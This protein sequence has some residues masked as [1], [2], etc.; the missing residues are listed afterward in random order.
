MGMEAIISGSTMATIGHVVGVDADEFALLLHVGDDV[1][2]GNLGGGAGGGGNGDDGHA[3]VLGGSDALQAAHV[4]KFGVGDD[5]ADGLGGVHGG[6]AADGDDVVGAGS[7]E[8]RDAVLNVF[9]GGV[10]FDV[11]SKPRRQDRSLSSTS[12]TLEVTPNLIRSLS[13]TTR[14]FLKARPFASWTMDCDCAG[15]DVRGFVEDHSVLPWESPFPFSFCD[16]SGS[17]RSGIG[18]QNFVTLLS[19][20]DSQR[21]SSGFRKV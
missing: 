16:L 9:D 1:V 7:R 4:R 20:A 13:V 2:D 14:A 17:R 8:G 3:R 11:A 15:A 18:E 21:F 6:A 12:V 5:D 19:Y 10:G